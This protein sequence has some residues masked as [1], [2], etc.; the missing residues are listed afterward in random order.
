MRVTPAEAP[1]SPTPSDRNGAVRMVETTFSYTQ[2][3]F[4]PRSVHFQFT[5]SP[6]SVHVGFHVRGSPC[7]GTSGNLWRSTPD[8][9]NHVELCDRHVETRGPKGIRIHWGVPTFHGAAS[10]TSSKGVTKGMVERAGGPPCLRSR[11]TRGSAGH[12][13]AGGRDNLQQPVEHRSARRVSGRPV[14]RSVGLRGRSRGP[15]P[16]DGVPLWTAGTIAARNPRG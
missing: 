16:G 15:H 14:S 10:Q 4:S 7:L 2:S 8:G 9:G 11:A 5:F 3:T 12:G 1:P 6:L 13:L